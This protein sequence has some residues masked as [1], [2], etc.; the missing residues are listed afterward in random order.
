MRSSATI[1]ED[2]TQYTRA[3]SSPVMLPHWRWSVDKGDVEGAPLGVLPAAVE[4]LGIVELD[5]G[6]QLSHDANSSNA[7]G[8]T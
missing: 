6:G 3:L 8:R 1:S 4:G 2:R 7:S 5:V